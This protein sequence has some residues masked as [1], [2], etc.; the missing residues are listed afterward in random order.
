MRLWLLSEATHIYTGIEAVTSSSSQPFT[1][2]CFLLR[3]LRA[4]KF[5]L[6]K[7]TK[8]LEKYLILRAD[9]PDWF[10]NLDPASDSNLNEL[11]TKGSAVDN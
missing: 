5:D 10:L 11:L 6:Q 9:N 7:A 1:N 2:D 4:Q 3:F 8:M